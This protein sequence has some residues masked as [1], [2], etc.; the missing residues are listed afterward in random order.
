[1]HICN[2]MIQIDTIYIYLLISDINSIYFFSKINTIYTCKYKL[3]KISLCK[4]F[5]YGYSYYY[6]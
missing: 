1:M 4:I 5:L 3:N 6:A 2:Y